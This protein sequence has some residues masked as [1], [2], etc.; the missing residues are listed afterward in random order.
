MDTRTIDF[1]PEIKGEDIARQETV[2]PVPVPVPF[3]AIPNTRVT[4]DN[5]ESTSIQIVVTEGKGNEES[6]DE[7]QAHQDSLE[8]ELPDDSYTTCCVKAKPLSLVFWWGPISSA[9]MEAADV[10]KGL[11]ASQTTSLPIIIFG[12]LAAA[13]SSFGLTG[14]DT[15][16]NF[17]EACYIITYRKFPREWP[18]LSLKKEIASFS[19]STFT[20]L[21]SPFAEGAQ[22]YYFIDSLPPDW[23]FNVNAAA[24]TG[25]SSLIGGGVGF[26]TAITDNI[27][28]LKSAREYIADQIQPFHNTCSKWGGFVL[29]PPVALCK[30]FQDNV[31]T[32]IAIKTIFNIGSSY[33]KVAIVIPGLINFIPKFSYE[34]LSS[35][36]VF[37]EFFGHISQCKIEPKKILAFS[38]S[39]GIGFLVAFLKQ[40]INK[41]FYKSIGNDLGIDTNSI[42]PEAYTFLSWAIFVD[43]WQRITATLFPPMN[44]SV[45]KIDNKIRSLWSMIYD[46][47]C[48]PSSDEEHDEENTRPL[49]LDTD[50]IQTEKQSALDANTLPNISAHHSTLYS[51]KN[52]R[53][54][55]ADITDAEEDNIERDGIEVEPKYR[56]CFDCVIS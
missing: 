53:N 39:A 44:R 7:S 10:G 43:E 27:D 38:M 55:A 45:D 16:E 41:E 49:L 3:I 12:S 36:Y 21:W 13:V 51:S 25:F 20:L 5:I 22:A 17:K 37:D 33:G 26:T 4:T 42:P 35:V 47:C 31:Q 1:T 23:G 40:P 6:D 29:G 14:D 2:I 48:A 54:Y 46:Y 56:R 50:D 15:R 19:L 8:E 24:W 30:T 18:K 28:L 9:C 32:Y 11:W 52:A 34:T